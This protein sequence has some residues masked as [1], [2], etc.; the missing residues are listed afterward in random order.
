MC[1]NYNEPK[2][3]KRYFLVL[4]YNNTVVLISYFIKT[5]VTDHIPVDDNPVYIM[6]KKI[7]LKRN[8]AYEAITKSSGKPSL[9]I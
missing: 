7:D 9:I 1:C 3:Q 5:D 8:I 2:K 6:M 4:L